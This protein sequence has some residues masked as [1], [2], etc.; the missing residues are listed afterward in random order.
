[1]FSHLEVGVKNEGTAENSSSITCQVASWHHLQKGR[2]SSGCSW[3]LTFQ[4]VLER[5]IFL[6]V[7]YYTPTSFTVKEREEEKLSSFNNALDL[8]LDFHC[9]HM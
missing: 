9:C 2:L 5:L 4:S 1:M 7:M 3:D 6:S 8:W